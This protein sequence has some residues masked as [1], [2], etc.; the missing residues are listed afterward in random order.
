MEMPQKSP[1]WIAWLAL[2]LLCA[3]L[4]ACAIPHQPTSPAAQ[5]CAAKGGTWDAENVRITQGYCAKG[6]P[7]QCQ[8][9]G[10]RWQRVCMMG[11]LACVKPYADA[12]KACSDG[13]QCAGRRCLMAPGASP[14]VVPQTG[15][16]IANDN[17]CHFGTNVVNGRAVAT[18]VAD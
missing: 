4:V 11:T 15:R 9:A 7:A 6:T 10:G 2:G 3:G 18:P 16:C 14:L 5:A 8:A 17:P 12:G 1:R 13:S